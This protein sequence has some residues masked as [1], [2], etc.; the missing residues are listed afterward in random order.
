MKLNEMFIG[1]LQQEQA[2]T[3][4]MLERIPQEKW[5]WRPHAKSLTMGELASHIANL[6]SWMSMTVEQ[7]ALDMAPPG[8]KPAITPQAANAAAAIQAL[9]QTCE[10]ALT[11]ICR[12]PGRCFPVD[13]RS[14]PCPATR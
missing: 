10:G 4:K 3:V 5:D 1:E 6:P 11:P 13:R 14:L 7:D 8:E 2:N 12:A 9:N